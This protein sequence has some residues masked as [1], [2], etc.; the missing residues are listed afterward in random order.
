LG[1]NRAQF[2]VGSGNWNYYAG[3]TGVGPASDTS[4]HIA[5][6]RVSNA[7]TKLRFDRGADSTIT[8]GT[9]AMTGLTLGSIYDNTSPAQM[10]LGD[11]HVWSGLLSDIDM[12]LAMETVNAYYGINALT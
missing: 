6:I 11:I 5:G 4:A 3:A 1:G 12:L 10:L 8:V 2:S 9:N 7:S